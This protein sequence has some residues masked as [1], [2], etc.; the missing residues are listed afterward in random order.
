M[1]LQTSL[2]TLKNKTRLEKEGE[3]DRAIGNHANEVL[4]IKRVVR[5]YRKLSGEK[6]GVFKLAHHSLRIDRKHHRSCF[7]ISHLLLFL[8][9]FEW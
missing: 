3:R 9:K 8:M 6:N 7:S 2:F 4:K 5:G 1:S